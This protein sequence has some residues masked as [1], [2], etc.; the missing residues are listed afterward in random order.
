MVFDSTVSEFD[1]SY[2]Q[3]RYKAWFKAKVEKALADPHPAIP[4][5]QVVA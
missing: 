4:H 2:H 3:E 5:Y 1:S